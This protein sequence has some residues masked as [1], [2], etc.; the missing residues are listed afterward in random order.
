MSTSPMGDARGMRVV[1]V[2]HC[3]LNQNSVVR[4]LAVREGMLEEIV[5]VL[6]EFKLGIIQLPCPETGYLGLKR[7]WQVRDQYDSVGFR[8]YC[9]RLAEEAAR[10][11]L[12]FEKNGIKVVSIIGIR[13]SPSC[14][15]TETSTGWVGGNP[16]EAGR[17]EKIKGKGVFMEELERAFRKY[18]LSVKM[19]D[20]NV[21]SLKESAQE[22]RSFLRELT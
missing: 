11:A 12:E 20:V 5:D 9:K 15:V 14:G 10:L 21:S 22:I 19:T 4:G 16:A 1:F 7:W 2:S 17:Y 18:G 8:R 6:R 13:G 3:V